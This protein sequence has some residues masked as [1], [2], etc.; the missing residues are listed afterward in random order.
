MSTII[1]PEAIELYC[2]TLTENEEISFIKKM[3]SLFD[4][5][6]LEIDP[7]KEED[8]SNERKILDRY[9]LF[10][11][12]NYYKHHMTRTMCDILLSSGNAY[13]YGG[14]LRDNILHD[15]MA[16][17]F[18][19]ND[20]LGDEFEDYNNPRIDKNT[21]LRT[22]VPQDIDVIF[23]TV[24]NYDQFILKL[25]LLGY[26]V[27]DGMFVDAYKTPNKV[28][29]SS[30]IK[31]EVRSNVG[32]QDLKGEN[33][34]FIDIDFTSV[35]IT[36]DVTISNVYVPS[37]DFMCNS[38]ILSQ[39]GFMFRGS[40]IFMSVK[41]FIRSKEMELKKIKTI[42]EQIHKMEAV[43]ISDDFNTCPVPLKH[44][45]LKMVKKGWIIKYADS[46]SDQF[47]TQRD[48]NED[49][50]ILCRNEFREVANVPGMHKL[51]DGVKFSCCSAVY[52]PLCLIELLKKSRHYI[53]INTNFIRYQCIQ[54]ANVSLQFFWE[55]M[56]ELL[57]ILNE[58]WDEVNLYGGL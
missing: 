53:R 27:Y 2:K 7:K 30:R 46:G 15:Y 42:E 40:N 49:C 5:K 12:Q 21:S 25:K 10:M 31:L 28:D 13:I 36:I 39:D 54:C 52:H 29:S 41:Q 4:S 23:H 16:L 20:K 58:S 57:I 34:R 48:N 8:D 11:K 32:I 35:F 55:K 24:Q 50:C 6:V 17:K 33:R 9:Q 38:L 51:Y 44:R 37:Y 14:L 18:Y 1:T 47:I 26:I 56:E 22:L 45:V 3:K 43:I 19:N